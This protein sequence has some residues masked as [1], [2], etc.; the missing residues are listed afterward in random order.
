M[1]IYNPYNPNN[2]PIL[3]EDVNKILASVGISYNTTRIDLFQQAFVHS[4]YVKRKDYTNQIT[5]EPSVLAERPAGSM[6]LQESSYERLEF[7]GDKEL[8]KAITNYVFM[9]FEHADEHFLT[10]LRSRIVNNNSIGELAKKL[11]FGKY[12]VI[13]KKLEGF[14][15][16]SGKD[17]IPFRENPGKLSD[18]FEAFIGAL[19][20][21]SFD[22]NLIYKFVTKL[23]EKYIDIVELI[24]EDNNYK[25]IFQTHCQK[26]FGYIP[27]Y[28]DIEETGVGIYKVYK[29]AVCGPGGK[30][31]ATASG[32]TKQGAQKEACRIALES[33]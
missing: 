17:L 20:L 22:A 19:W 12:L 2:V 26:T 15:V 6:E 5:G 10:K 28:K 3:K 25:E 33:V 11:G 18:I 1:N 14:N 16:K 4:S 21:D 8:D 32:N 9:R 24:S 27:F 30:I 13:S 31:F 23:I 29:V 7:L